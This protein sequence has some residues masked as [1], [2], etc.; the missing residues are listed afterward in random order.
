[1]EFMGGESSTTAYDN[2]VSHV[3]EGIASVGYNDYGPDWVDVQ[4]NGF[5]NYRVIPEFGYTLQHWRNIF[6]ALLVGDLEAVDQ[7]LTDSLETFHYDLI[8]YQDM[9]YNRTYYMIR[10]RLD[11]SYQDANQPLV[12]GDEVHG[13]FANG[14]GLFILNPE[15]ARQHVLV[16]IPHPNDDFISPYFGVEMFLQ[17]D[18]FALMISGAGREVKWTEYPP[19]SNNKSISDPSRNENTV[20]QMFHKVL[21]DSLMQIG[22][23]SPLVLHTHSFD[24]NSAHADFQSIVVSGGWDAGNANKP[25]RDLSDDNLDLINFTAEYPIPAGAYGDHPA[26]RVDDYYRIHYNGSLLYHGANQNYEMPHTYTLLG[27]NT[28]VQMN[29]LRQFFD[30][31]EV[32]EPWVQIELFEKPMLFQDMNMP[33][34]ELYAGEYPSSYQNYSI[35][36]DYYQPFID[37]LEAYLQNWGS[38]PDTTPPEAIDNWRTAFDGQ[39]YVSL[40][41]DPV[42]DTNHKTYRIYYDTD[43]L[44]QVSPYLDAFSEPRLF[45][46]ATAN[47]IFADLNPADNYVFQIQALDHFENVGP[48][49]AVIT[50]SLPGHESI[51]VL[52]NFD[53]GEIIL[54]SYSGEDNHPDMWELNDERTFMG[55]PFSL[56]LWGN[57]WKSQSIDPYPVEPASVFQLA[58]YV[59]HLGEIQGIAFQDPQNTLFYALD[60]SEQLDIEEWITVYQGYFA[61]DVWNLFRLPIGDDWFARFDYY[62]QL[63]NIIYIN[64]RDSDPNARVYFDEFFDITNSI[65][66][67]PEVSIGYTHRQVY[68]NQ[69]HQR[70]VDVNF[71]AMVN[72]ADSDSHTYFWNFGDGETSELSAP[73]HTFLVED[74][75][76]YTVM[77]QVQ[78]ESNNWGQAIVE[79]SVDDGE[80]SF[81]LTMNFVGDIM[82]ARRYEDAGGILE[83]SGVSAI[84]EPTQTILGDAADLTIANLECAMT[85]DGEEHPTKSVV[86]KGRPEYVTG[87]A[88]AGIDLVTLANNHTLDYGIIGLQ[89]TQ[90]A[91]IQN[92]ILFSGSG[93]NTYEAYSPVFTNTKGVAIAWLANCDRT[94]QYNNAQPY[95]NAGYNKPG[96]AYLTPYYLLQQI[97]AV[98]DI[99]DLVVMEMH[100]GSEYSSEPGAG[101]DSFEFGVGIPAEDWIAPREI[102]ENMDLPQDSDEDENYS[103]LLDVPHM[104]DREIRHFAIDSGSDLVIVHHPHIIQG[105]EVYNGKL[106]AHSLGNYV[107]DLNYHETFPSVILNAEINADGFAA[108]SATPVYLDDY[109]PRPATG[110]LGTHLLDYL[111]KKSRALDTYLYVDQENVTASIWLDTLSMPRTQIQNRRA[112]NLELQGSN[113]ISPPIEIH[114]QGNPSALTAPAEPGW[115]Y[116]LGRELLWYGNM[117]DEG[118]SQ[119]NTNS[120]DEWLDITEAYTGER[121]IGQHRTPASGD[122][123]ITNLE[124]R[125]RVNAGKLHHI[126]AYLKTQN[127][128]NAT[129]QIRYYTGRTTSSVLATHYLTSG[130]DGTHDWTYYHNETIPPYNANYFDIRLNT[131]MPDMGDA[132]SW[133][134]D[135][136]VIEWT[137]WGSMPISQISSPNDLYFL[138]LRNS[139]IIADPVVEFVETIYNAPQPVTVELIANETIALVET[140]IQFSDL[141]QGFVG[142]WE[143]DFGDGQSSFEQNPTHI[144]SAPGFY[145]VSLTILDNLGNPLTQSKPDYI[146]IFSQYLPGDL[147]FDGHN[148]VS[149]IVVLVNIIIGEI[150]PTTPQYESG[151]VNGD[152]NINVQ[153]LVSLVN[154]ILFD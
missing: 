5:G 99:S 57:T 140:A 27:P 22:P 106:I 66:F 152:G 14:W 8:E 141:S 111:A 108:Y 32:Y 113:W 68:R 28:G 144:Y 115:E 59:E 136:H 118:S 100:A 20:F 130:V 139:T 58:V 85:I 116:R 88:D 9:L 18:A 110:V 154:I 56:K 117:E 119:W 41:W 44:T 127:S 81:P 39:T 133:F 153:D 96:F 129:I 97:N 123:V 42:F 49:S 135:V 46:P 2:Y 107:F 53:D 35:L 52:E 71:N 62:P 34:T 75:H 74:D 26:L 72:D 67:A 45:N 50:D 120:S 143:W 114:K 7:M 98:S 48:L 16:E 87:L 31:G 37:A 73:I 146:R 145:D 55:S 105:F 30:N 82:I 102:T 83:T 134:D 12:F 137:D 95:L 125:I 131:D 43:S 86:F 126:T 21:C 148:T 122:N 112:F 25:I 47:H 142:W 6:E 38:V 33:L 132:Y 150:T 104:W 121:S 84:F 149:D 101:Y 24:D 64:D 61:E 4:T 15:A 10:E 80:S 109:I 70:S 103:P 36:M 91:L 89:T 63:T 124:N 93:M 60:G 11:L 29:Y 40:E 78:D 69:A 79:I 3:S 23:H 76:N 94:G 147:N 90:E 138:Q 13:S 128:N 151:D 92:N 65:A 51:Y 19:Y 17:T 77:L 1:M 54:E